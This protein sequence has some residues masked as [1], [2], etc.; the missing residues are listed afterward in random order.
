MRI[1]L[2][3]Q[4]WQGCI[5]PLYDARIYFKLGAGDGNRTRIVGLE[6]QHSTIELLPQKSY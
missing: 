5:L 4:P 6:N 2:T 3:S 1:E